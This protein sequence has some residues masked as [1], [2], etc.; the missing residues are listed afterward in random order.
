MGRPSSATAREAGRRS[1]RAAAPQQEKSA[2]RLVALGPQPRS[3]LEALEAPVGG[4][5]ADGAVTCDNAR[6]VTE[7]WCSRAGNKPGNVRQAAE[8]SAA[9]VRR[10]AGCAARGG[11]LCARWRRSP[12]SGAGYLSVGCSGMGGTRAPCGHPPRKT[13][14]QLR[15]PSFS[16]RWLSPRRF[17][18]VAGPQAC[19][20]RAARLALS[21]DG[22][23]TCGWRCRRVKG[24][25]GRRCAWAGDERA[26]WP[27]EIKCTGAPRRP[28]IGALAAPG[29][30]SRGVAP[31][32][33]GV[34]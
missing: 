12:D 6:C 19:A 26:A 4:C 24:A 8:A 28:G 7:R 5:W 25:A 32:D 14:S 23:I 9:M 2:R 20:G 18:A 10:A 1:P 16:V 22:S 17:C 30:Y 34:V 3:G 27:I 33:D 11:L 15:N 21:R 31:S 29:A 13:R